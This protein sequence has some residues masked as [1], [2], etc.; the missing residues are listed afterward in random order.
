MKFTKGMW[1]AQITRI[2]RS[3]VHYSYRDTRKGI[4]Q[5]PKTEFQQMISQGDVVRYNISP[6]S[7]RHLYMGSNPSR[8]GDFDR[9]VLNRYLPVTVHRASD[10]KKTEI[11]YTHSYISYIEKGASL[12]NC[13]SINRTR[14]RNIIYSWTSADLARKENWQS[15][16][17]CDLSHFPVDAVVFWNCLQ[18]EDKKPRSQKVREFMT[19]PLNYIFERS[20]DNRRRGRGTERYSEPHVAE[21]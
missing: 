3:R 11:L 10:L 15:L 2:S 6:Q 4:R 1:V 5:T 17:G 8:W 18:G 13:S 20:G 16:E 21:D 7:N 14:N 19:N 9:R 12:N